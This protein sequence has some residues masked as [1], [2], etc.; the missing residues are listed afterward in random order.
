MTIVHRPDFLCRVGGQ[1][2]RYQNW[3]KSERVIFHNIIVSIV[4]IEERRSCCAAVAAVCIPGK[5]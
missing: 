1:T 5:A 3:K 4:R 2:K